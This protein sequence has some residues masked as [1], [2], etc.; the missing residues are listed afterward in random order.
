MARIKRNGV[1]TDLSFNAGLK[2]TVWRIAV[3]IRLSKEDGND[4]SESVVNQKKILIEYLD[5][6]FA[7]RFEIADF[8]IDDGLTGTDATRANFMRMVHDIENDKVNCVV[9]KTLARA[10]RNYSDQGYYLEFLFPKKNVRF[11][12]TGD[13]H[14]DTFKIP[15]LSTGLKSRSP[16]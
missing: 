13:P 14:I 8:Y 3:Y 11:I 16:G 1:E 5:K 4:E 6:N 15:K 2:Q 12:S 10:F 7:E 9:C